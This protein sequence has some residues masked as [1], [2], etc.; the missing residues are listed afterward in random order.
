MRPVL[1]GDISNAARALLS[2]PEGLRAALCE[3]MIFE[4]EAADSY[5]SRVGRL[6]PQWGNGSLM[7]AARKRILADEP[8][9]DDVDYCACFEMVLRRLIERRASPRRS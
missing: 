9:F 8:T 6:H 1:H 3:R 7:S 5:V 4:S 2:V